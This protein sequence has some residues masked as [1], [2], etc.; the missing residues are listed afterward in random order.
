[1]IYVCGDSFSVSDPE[2]GP[3]WV[4][5]LAERFEICNL[6]E[7]AATNLLIARQVQQAIDCGARFVIMNATSVTRG[8]KQ[9]NNRYV[10]FSYH[11]AS[12]LTTPF[13]DTQLQILKDYFTEFFDLELAIL[14]NKIT[15]EHTLQSLVDSGIAFRFDQGGFE[16]P[17]FG[18]VKTGYFAKF[19]QWR[20]GI[21]LWNY[22]VSRSFRPYYHIMD[23]K[24]HAMVAD[25]Y[26]EQIQQSL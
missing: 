20:S 19:D 13:S 9:I 10:P 16:H 12:R 25:Y 2:Y 17:N 22:T 6:A 5:M 4:D 3:C 15:I 7:T 1:M 23:T 24:V 8:E 21:N 14:Q 11:T 18:N 26:T